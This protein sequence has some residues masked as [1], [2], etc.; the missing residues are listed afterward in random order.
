MLGSI[1][2]MIFNT[3]VL[4]VLGEFR[5]VNDKGAGSP[6]ETDEMHE[7][8]AR[9]DQKWMLY[10]IIGFWFILLVLIE[11][12]LLSFCCQEM[13]K[14]TEE[15]NEVFFKDDEDYYNYSG[16]GESSEVAQILGEGTDLQLRFH[17]KQKPRK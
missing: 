16:A 4:K 11:W 8:N 1:S 3:E 5:E 7:T 14:I 17:I 9:L 2:S 10:H 12:R 13:D 6:I 15:D